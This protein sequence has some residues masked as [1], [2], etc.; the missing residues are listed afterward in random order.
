[1]HIFNLFF[2][3]DRLYSILHKEILKSLGCRWSV[4]RRIQRRGEE[5]RWKNAREKRNNRFLVHSII[6]V[7]KL[8]AAL[9]LL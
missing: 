2:S 1:M 5:M 4:A 8:F 3:V 7:A 6:A 9:L